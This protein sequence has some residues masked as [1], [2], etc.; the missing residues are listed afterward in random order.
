MSLFSR[1][2]LMAAEMDDK[3]RTQSSGQ[4][5]LRDA[6]RHLMEWSRQNHHA[7][8]TEDLPVIFWE[9][10]GVDTSVILNRWMQPTLR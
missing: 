1:G 3:I 7:F 8:R 4:K 2:A 9:A 6:L 10:T 5:S